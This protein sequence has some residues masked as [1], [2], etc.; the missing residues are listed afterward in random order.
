M[1]PFLHWAPLRVS[2]VEF[3][4]VGD[5]LDEPASPSTRLLR[6]EAWNAIL[7]SAAS[8]LQQEWTDLNQS[9]WLQLELD[10]RSQMGCV[11]NL[12][13]T[14]YFPIYNPHCTTMLSCWYCDSINY[15]CEEMNIN[16]ASIPFPAKE[17]W[18]FLN[19]ELLPLDLD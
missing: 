8:R 7:L 4:L 9:H 11:G 2:R 14:G 1:E 12:W 6:L 15:V 13:P 10:I 3:E 19:F 5:Y 18:V 16:P 17:F